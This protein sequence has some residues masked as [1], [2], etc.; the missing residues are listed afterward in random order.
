MENGDGMIGRDQCLVKAFVAIIGSDHS[1]WVDSEFM[2]Q[3]DFFCFFFGHHDGGCRMV[4]IGMA[5][6][7]FLAIAI[8]RGGY[9]AMP[10]AHHLAVLE[11]NEGEQTYD[12]NQFAHEDGVYCL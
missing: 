11:G 8:D 10:I 1:K 5:S 2:G 7:C 3:E 4:F 6:E 12:G 9:P